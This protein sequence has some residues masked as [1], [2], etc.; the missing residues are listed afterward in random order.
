M[1][2]SLPSVDTLPGSTPKGY[3]RNYRSWSAL[4]GSIIADAVQDETLKRMLT[5]PTAVF[6]SWFCAEPDFTI[7][8]TWDVAGPHWVETVA[9]RSNA[10]AVRA[11]SLHPVVYAKDCV[12][13][14]NFPKA[15]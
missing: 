10:A 2:L 14:I 13:R 7:Y 6:H 9:D 8:D 3:W 5:E 15:A 1:W 11:L 4:V 12:L